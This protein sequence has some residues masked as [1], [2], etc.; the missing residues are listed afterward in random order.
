M[1]GI[2]RTALIASA[3][4][5]PVA[6]APHPLLVAGTVVPGVPT[7]ETEIRS[8]LGF[9]DRAR[10]QHDV[11]VLD[12]ILAPEFAAVTAAGA[13]LDRA[14]LLEAGAPELGARMIE[15]ENLVIHLDG[16]SATATSRVVRIGTPRGDETADVTSE[17][18]ILRRDGESWLIVS[19]ASAQP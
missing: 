4:L 16:S 18:L 8:V 12:R 10:A 5:A 11:R 9:W 6:A 14:A 2:L 7:P 1:S 3:A 13:R 19:S 15:R 17:T